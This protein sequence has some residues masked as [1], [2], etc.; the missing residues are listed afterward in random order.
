[1]KKRKKTLKNEDSDSEHK[2][3]VKRKV[4]KIYHKEI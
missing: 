4:K 2:K 3:K 1:M